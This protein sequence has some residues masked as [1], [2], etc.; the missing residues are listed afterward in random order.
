MRFGMALQLTPAEQ[1]LVAEAESTCSR[2]LTA[3][4]DVWSFEKEVLAA[5]TLDREGGVLCNSVTILAYDVGVSIPSSK[6]ILAT[7]CREY[8]LRHAQQVED[9]L[10]AAAS[11]GSG[12]DPE[13]L[14]LY[15][16]GLACQMG[17]NEAWSK[18]THRYISNAN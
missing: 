11:P 13:K 7:I 17:G 16:D 8:E 14:R 3:L 5:E 18:M 2:Q 9:V 1:K 6:R 12:A 10:R 4:N 15:L